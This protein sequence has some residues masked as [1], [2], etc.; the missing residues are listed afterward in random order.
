MGNPITL[1]NN[2]LEVKVFVYM[3]ITHMPKD[4]SIVGSRSFI[5]LIKP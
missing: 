1:C 4:I 2:R 5:W 3:I